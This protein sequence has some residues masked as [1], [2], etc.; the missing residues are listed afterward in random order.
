MGNEDPK[1]RRHSE[2]FRTF[3]ET[4]VLPEMQYSA[5]VAAYLNANPLPERPVPPPE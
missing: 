2:K 4:A 3:V 5:M 1:L